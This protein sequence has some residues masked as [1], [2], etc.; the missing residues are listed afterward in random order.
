MAQSFLRRLRR[1]HP[2]VIVS[3]LPRSGTSM[4]MRMLEAG[5]LP[6][7]TDG[8]RAADTSNPNGY[9]EFERVKDFGQ[10]RRLAWLVD[11]R[12]KARENHLAAAHLPAGV[13]RLPG[14]LHAARPRRDPRVPE[15]DAGGAGE[16]PG[17]DDAR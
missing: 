12:G 14:D 10:G 13:V 1:G 7:V 5:G 3:G 15:Q 17:A 11:A 6:V 16:A 9:Y 8:V 4:A 2:I